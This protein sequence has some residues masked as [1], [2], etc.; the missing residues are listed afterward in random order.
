MNK[1][2]REERDKLIVKDF[3][4]NILP[5]DIATKHNV[6]YQRILQILNENGL[7]IENNS[8]KEDDNVI[9]SACLEAIEKGESLDE[10]FKIWG[11]SK[12]YYVLGKKCIKPGKLV[13]ERRNTL[14]A[15]DFRMG[16][17]PKVIA[18]KYEV[19]QS[20][21]YELLSKMG[22]KTFPTTIEIKKRNQKIRKLYSTKKYTQDDLALDFNL[23]RGCIGLILTF[24]SPYQD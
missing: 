6:T 10:T 19:N 20:Y 21:V 5:Q 14:I 7:S 11:R 15:E 1:E 9:I 22:L 17:P 18:E 4:D 8:T 2:E 23:S 24:A 12:V 16:L 13:N 3:E